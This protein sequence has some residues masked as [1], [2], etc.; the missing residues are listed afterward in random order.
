MSSVTL[1]SSDGARIE[2]TRAAMRMCRLVSEMICDGEPDEPETETVPILGVGAAELRL[3]VMFCE[4]YASA[5]SPGPPRPRAPLIST[6]AKII[7][8]EWPWVHEFFLPGALWEG[9]LSTAE[10]QKRL[11]ELNKAAWRIEAES[12][13]A[14]TSALIAAYVKGKTP[15]QIRE[16]LA[17]P[18]RPPRLLVAGEDCDDF[19]IPLSY[20]KIVSDVVRR[21]DEQGRAL[22]LSESDSDSGSDEGEAEE[23]DDPI[24][25]EEE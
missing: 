20:F 14:T 18:A 4:R 15:R 10:R 21:R 11:F 5:S 19:G 24:E 16:T 25:E 22:S 9:P 13:C 6:D 8:A 23:H 17:V 7:F 2:T 12:L 1:V 3:I